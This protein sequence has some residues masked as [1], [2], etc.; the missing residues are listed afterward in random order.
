MP[1]KQAMLAARRIL[2]TEEAVNLGAMHSGQL[3]AA[4]EVF[5]AIIDEET[6]GKKTDLADVAN[7]IRSE[8]VKLAERMDGDTVLTVNWLKTV[9]FNIARQLSRDSVRLYATAEHLDAF[10]RAWPQADDELVAD[11]EPEIVPGTYNGQEGVWMTVQAW[12]PS[13]VTEDEAGLDGVPEQLREALEVAAAVIARTE[14]EL[15]GTGGIM[16]DSERREIRAALR[17]TSDD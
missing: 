6:A 2:Q 8:A 4:S 17:E 11:D 16:Y 10:E 3:D 15:P 9:L 12:V 1:S 7:A 13:D 14:A 5:A